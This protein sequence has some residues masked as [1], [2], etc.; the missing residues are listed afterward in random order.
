MRVFYVVGTGGSGKTTLTSILAYNLFLRNYRV[1]IL[2]LTGY[3]KGYFFR[4]GACDFF[5]LGDGGIEIPERLLVTLQDIGELML[6]SPLQC[7]HSLPLMPGLKLCITSPAP[8]Q[9][10]L[11]PATA[12]LELYE[13]FFDVVFVEMRPPLQFFRQRG[14]EQQD[15]VLLICSDARDDWPAKDALPAELSRSRPDQ[16]IVVL[17]KQTEN[18]AAATRFI[19]KNNLGIN[20]ILEHAGDLL[21]NSTV[22]ELCKQMASSRFLRQ[23]LPLIEEVMSK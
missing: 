10:L 14:F 13:E 4:F 20:H 17:N 8:R 23:I 15:L 5:A 12:F 1:A 19:E 6:D 22:I 21:V 18:L 11:A 2:D 9:E 3:G 16:V 7:L